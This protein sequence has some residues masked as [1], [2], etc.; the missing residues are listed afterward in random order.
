MFQL[1]VGLPKVRVLLMLIIIVGAAY[2][3]PQSVQSCPNVHAASCEPEGQQ[4]KEWLGQ[5]DE[6]LRKEGVLC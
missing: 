1:R 3:I 6:W 2:R 5:E 4:E